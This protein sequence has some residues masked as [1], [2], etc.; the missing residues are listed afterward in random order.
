[1]RPIVVDIEV[2]VPASGRIDNALDNTDIERAGFSGTLSIL[3]TGSAAG[4]RS[5]LL[6]GQ[7]AV[8]SRRIVNTQNRS[9]VVPDDLVISD[10]DASEGQTIRLAVDNTTV[11]A[12]TYRARA[13]FEP[14]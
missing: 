4:L 8:F 3:E 11:G 6:V 5:T 12:L 1:M 13:I 9:P 14:Y 2:S 10:V 7:D